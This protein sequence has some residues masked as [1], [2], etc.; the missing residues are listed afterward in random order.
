MTSIEQFRSEAEGINNLYPTLHYAPENGYP[1][2]N[3][4]IVL[5][6][7]ELLIDRYEVRIVPS[8]NYPFRFPHVF[9]TGGRIPHNI[10]WHVYADGHSCIKSVPEEILISKKGIALDKF[11]NEQVIP[12]FFNQK[13]REMHGF[14]LHERKHGP[15][16]NLEFFEE[17]FN[18]KDHRAIGRGLLLLRDKQLPNRVSNCFCG[19]GKKYRKCHKKVLEELCLFSKEELEWFLQMILDKI[20]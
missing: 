18:T 17:L 8:E 11:I 4:S 15:D 14:F 13:H 1:V 5:Q 2:I 10:D 12:Y 9:E 16:G 20:A 19:N 3:G 7:D 6:E